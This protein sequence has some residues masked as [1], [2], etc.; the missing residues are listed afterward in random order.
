MTNRIKRF[1]FGRKR[2]HLFRITSGAHLSTNLVECS[3]KPEKK[4]AFLKRAVTFHC[5]YFLK[6]SAG[7]FFQKWRA[8]WQNTKRTIISHSRL[9]LLRR[10]K[11]PSLDLNIT[12]DWCIASEKRGGIFTEKREREKQER[13]SPSV[14]AS[15]FHY[16]SNA[17]IFWHDRRMLT[18]IPG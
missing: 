14:R 15:S 4:K 11:G 16:R 7:F 2:A 13:T 8:R 6:A 5:R 9:L 18:G 3:W 10:V 17:G 12:S 1:H